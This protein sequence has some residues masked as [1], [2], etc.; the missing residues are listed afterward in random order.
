MDATDNNGFRRSPLWLVVLAGLVA[1]QGWLT[2]QLFGAD[3]SLEQLT[4]DA[5]ILDGR[6]PLHFYHGLL[7]NRVWHERQ[8][9]M[10]YDP[11]FQAGYLKTPIF[12]G[13]SR[14]AELFLFLGGPSAGSYKLGLAICCLFPPL[15]FALAARGIGLGAGGACLTALIGGTLWWS[16]ACRALL[17]TGDI[18][19]LVGGICVP[20]YLAWLYRFGHS[21][22][23][24]E[25]LV[26][27]CSAAIGW[28]AQPLLMVVTVSLALLYHVWVFR[29]MRLVWH[30]SL[31]FANAIGLGINLFWLHDWVTHIGLY[32]PY[33]GEESPPRLWPST[34]QNWEAFIPA[35]PVD[36][37]ISV[38]GV[39]GLVSMLRRRADAAWLFGIGIATFVAAAGA[40]QLWPMLAEFGTHKVMSVGVWCCALPCSYA[41]MA[42]ANGFS[43]STEVK[44]VGA[45][46]LII[47]LGGLGYTLDI[48]RRWEVMPLQIGLGAEREEIVKTIRESTTPEGRILWE[49]RVE[50]SRLFGWTALLPELTQRHFI[51]GLTPD[52]CV[53][54]LYARLADGKLMNRPV[55]QWTDDELTKLFQRYN[56]TRVVAWTQESRERFGKM[57]TLRHIAELKDGGVMYAIDR[58]PGYFLKGS[59]LVTQMDWKR[60]ALADLKPD[61]DGVVVLS[62]HH[63]HQ[64][65]VTPGYVA[66]E[67]DVDVNDPIPMIRLRLPDPVA[68][69]TLTWQGH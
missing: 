25:W 4:N 41:L 60:V 31:L 28:Y 39:I 54:H 11:A 30:I 9:T 62:L 40:G 55:G 7:A 64:W 18:D 35:D 50:G 2:L 3:D 13:G 66:I 65:R 10:C 8:A 59:G 49:D 63:H 26:I 57:P 68:R 46:W 61:A 44:P 34:F 45:I 14:P 37:G 23:P 12:D 6:H 5:P 21:P 51:G 52:Q 19:L 29:E 16:P 15:A 24:M 17:E 36:L 69:V 67:K 1:C 48:P 58:R 22:G 33:G 53:D 56:V 43:A 20:V 38:I 47:A 27:A 32:V 42:L